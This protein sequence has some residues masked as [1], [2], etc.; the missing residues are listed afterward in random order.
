MVIL[1]N[2]KAEGLLPLLGKRP[3][4]R[5]QATVGAST[6]GPTLQS[7]NWATRVCRFMGSHPWCL[8]S[9]LLG[10]CSPPNLPG[11]QER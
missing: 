4:A 10:H 6:S 8:H 5:S 3:F 1:E 9:P 7:P 2:R 11:T